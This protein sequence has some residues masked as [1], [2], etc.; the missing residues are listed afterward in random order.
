MYKWLFTTYVLK[1]WTTWPEKR[2]NSSYFQS[3]DP[4]RYPKTNFE[5]YQERY[6]DSERGGSVA[7]IKT[8]GTLLFWWVLLLRPNMGD[9]DC[10]HVRFE[11]NKLFRSPTWRHK[12]ALD[13]IPG[14]CF[15]WT[16]F[17]LGLRFVWCSPENCVGTRFLLYLYWQ[18]LKEHYFLHKSL[19]STRNL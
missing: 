15:V 4:S 6:W 11:T 3:R 7:E 8:V 5:A 13:L 16:L 1:R 9:P 18:Y 19:C 17:I 12:Q 10:F 2:Q 14:S